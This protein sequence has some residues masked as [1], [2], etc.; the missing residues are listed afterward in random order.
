[1]ARAEDLSSLRARVLAT[2][3]AE[4]SATRR[5][6]RIRHARLALG[7]LL[8]PLTL[9]L[10]AGGTRP[11]P[12]HESL[13]VATAT[14]AALLAALALL[15]AFRRGRSMLGQPSSWLLA[16][17]LLTPL[18]LL[19]WKVAVSSRYPDMMLPWVERPG[20]RCLR[21]SGLFSVAPLLGALLLRRG[22]DPLHP[23]AA[24]AALGAAVG[25]G[26]WV[27]VDL[28]CPVAYVPH[29]LL[30]HVLPLVLTILCGAALG[31]RLLK[32]Q[33]S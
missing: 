29:L 19:A 14:G 27:L 1:M 26:T 5:Q 13:I 24:G 21:L 3:R 25:A 33:N 31:G 16:V 10:I 23:R 8:A 20:F 11:A 22:S 17:S 4:P 7:M 9:F 15:I 30:G 2:A 18:A 28:W 12:R 32:L 6:V